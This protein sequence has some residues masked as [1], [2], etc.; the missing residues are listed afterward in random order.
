MKTYQVNSFSKAFSKIGIEKGDV[1]FIHASILNFGWP[2]D[3][4]L[5]K[6]PEFL[7]QALLE[8]IGE[9]GTLVVPTFN[10]DFCNGIPFNKQES[11]SKNM[12]VFSEYIRKLRQAK[13]SFN[14]MQSV[15]VIGKHAD[16]LTENDTVTAFSSGSA[17]DRLVGLDA[18]LLLL[19]ADFIYNSV[20]HWI[21]QKH[22]VPYR[23]W[24]E[25]TGTYTD[26][27]FTQE[28]TYQ[29]FVRDRTLNAELD[30]QYIK[31]TL[32]KNNQLKTAKVGNGLI[33][34]YKLSEF[35]KISEEA[36]TKNPY[37][38]VINHPKFEKLETI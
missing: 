33:R 28:K 2:T 34:N 15:A 11:P 36:M 29:M 10:F 31:Q 8:K 37:F 23:Y 38:F 14:P 9:E 13:R 18:K 27:D 26:G 12:G 16:Y 21:E 35:I 24:K 30:F 25:F 1:L 6:L 3:I 22:E 5:N 7:Y 32:I 19:G 17:F 20:F 4:K